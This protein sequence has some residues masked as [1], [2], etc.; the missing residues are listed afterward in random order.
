M[1]IWPVLFLLPCLLLP[2]CGIR[3]REEALE[4]REKEINQKEQSLLL[5]EKQLQLKEEDLLRR[6][7]ILDSTHQLA[8]LD[9]SLINPKLVGKW[10]ATM[11]CTAT[12]CEGSAVGDVKNEL[13]NIA[14]QDRNVIVKAMAD[15][16]LVRT[17]TGAFTE[18]NLQLT[19]QQEEN[20]PQTKM[21]AQLTFRSDTELEG[22]RKIMRDNSCQIVYALTLSKQ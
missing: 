21:T 18:N 16:K 20:A 10:A 1:K 17:Y 3:E 22:E 2:S 4:Q 13:W 12:T 19:A 11:R 7:K 8:R 5:L 14:Y 15:G 9:S 6:Q